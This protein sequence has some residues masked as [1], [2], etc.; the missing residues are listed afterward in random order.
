MDINNIIKYFLEGSAVAATAY[1]F[2]NTKTQLHSVLTI[3]LV[4][5]ITF[6]ILDVFAPNV[7]AGTRL[8]SGFGIGNN[9]VGGE[10][11]ASKCTDIHICNPYRKICCPQTGDK[12]SCG[13]YHDCV[14]KN[15]AQDCKDETFLVIVDTLIYS[16]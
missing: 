4:A 10:D 14:N 8:G 6:F 7:A 16:L 5:S 1:Y 2:T 9:L 12:L 15:K 3:G 11:T 13:E